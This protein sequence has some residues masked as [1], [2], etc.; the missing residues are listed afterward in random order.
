[1]QQLV[2]L[3]NAPNQTFA[4]NL[5]VDGNPLTLNLVFR[6]NEIA[7]Y[8]AMTVKDASLNLLVNS[9]PLVTGN[10]PACNILRQFG[11]L[12]IGSAFVINQSGTKKLNYPNN[13]D[14]GTDFVLV[15]GDTP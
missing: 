2:P 11:Y 14:L 7:K 13:S 5:S 10:D 15:W 9:V 3:T 1:M 6:Y 4:A 8:W 12:K